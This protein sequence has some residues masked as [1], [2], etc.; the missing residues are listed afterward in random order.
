MVTTGG[1]IEK[2]I[3]LMIIIYNYLCMPPFANCS[4]SWLSPNT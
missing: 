3:I 4:S 2:S 1:N